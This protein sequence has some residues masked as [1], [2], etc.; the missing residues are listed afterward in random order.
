MLKGGKYDYKRRPLITGQTRDSSTLRRW[1]GAYVTLRP[2]RN[3]SRA[4]SK[5]VLNGPW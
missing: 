5:Y 2:G 4:D 1:F 3:L